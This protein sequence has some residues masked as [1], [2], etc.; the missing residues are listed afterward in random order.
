MKLNKIIAAA[1]FGS[2]ISISG[3]MS[4]PNVPTIATPN[5]GAM[6]TTP[7]AT[8]SPWSG[9]VFIDLR[10]KDADIVVLREV[11]SLHNLFGVKG[12]TGTASALAGYGINSG[13]G[14]TGGAFT[15]STKVA[16]EATLSFGF[17]YT[18]SIIK[19][20]GKFGFGPTVGLS[21]T[22]KG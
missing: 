13:T 10:H 21:V 22:F 4:A 20:F 2:L 11:G 15:F 5:L 9:A 14:V 6:Q 7:P 3:A 17:G 18:T 12:L 8:T 1:L 19:N 16:S